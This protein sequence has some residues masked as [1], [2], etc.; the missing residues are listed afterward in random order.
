MT[1]RKE[2]TGSC[3]DCGKPTTLTHCQSDEGPVSMYLCLGC[4]TVRIN[5]PAAVAAMEADERAAEE[6][7]S[8]LDQGGRLS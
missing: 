6:M 2:A 7:D 8:F 4:V 3:V 1:M 5:S